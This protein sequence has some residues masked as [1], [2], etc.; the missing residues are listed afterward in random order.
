M[1]LETLPGDVQLLL[2]RLGRLPA[3]APFYLAGGSAVALHLGHRRSVD[4][5]FFI[6]RDEFEMDVLLKDLRS[7]GQLTIQQQSRGTLNAALDGTQVSFFVYPYPLLED[8]HTLWQTE[9]AGLLDL[10]LMKLVS[11]SQRGAKRD[12]VDLYQVCHTVHTLDRL[13]AR[14]PEKYPKVTYPSYH[15]LRSLAYFEDAESDPMPKMLISMEW[16]EVKGFFKG[17][18]RRLMKQLL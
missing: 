6:A 4:L 16:Y 5:D 7:L 1:F 10:A 14:L 17:E 8:L 13:L 3:S 18:V 11:I 9:V 2:R 12:F 15:I